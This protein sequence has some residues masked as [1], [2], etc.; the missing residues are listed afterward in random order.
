MNRGSVEGDCAPA[1]PQLPPSTGREL[2]AGSIYK[3]SRPHSAPHWKGRNGFTGEEVTTLLPRFLPSTY[4]PCPEG[5]TVGPGIFSKGPLT[6]LWQL[7]KGL[8]VERK[9]GGPPPS[10][11]V[12][13]QALGVEAVVGQPGPRLSPSQV[14]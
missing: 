10:Q 1:S 2:G 14:R 5:G 8:R 9:A 11:A 4:C 7:W 3:R 12:Q 6:Y 13:V